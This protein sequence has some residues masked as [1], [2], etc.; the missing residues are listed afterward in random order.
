MEQVEARPSSWSTEPKHGFLELLPLRVRPEPRFSSPNASLSEFGEHLLAGLYNHN[1]ASEVKELHSALSTELSQLNR[2]AIDRAIQDLAE[3]SALELAR[4]LAVRLRAKF[5]DQTKSGDVIQAKP[6]NPSTVGIP[7][8]GSPAENPLVE[9]SVK[10]IGKEGRAVIPEG[11]NLGGSTTQVGQTPDLVPPGG[12]RGNM[13]ITANAVRTEIGASSSSQVDSA[14]TKSVSQLMSYD[15]IIF[16]GKL[17]FL[18]F[19]LGT[20]KVSL[21]PPPQR[22]R[23]K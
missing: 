16:A 21:F 10:D 5:G 3:E 9:K 11:K 14:G 15:F 23:A 2:Y 8:Q 20:L 18:M 4:S 13:E 12:L 1:A 19:G 7:R 17:S 6:L 22:T